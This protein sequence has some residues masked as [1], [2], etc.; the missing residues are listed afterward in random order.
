[1]DEL[2]QLD[3]RRRFV[4]K[5]T[6]LVK[7]ISDLILIDPNGQLIQLREQLVNSVVPLQ[8]PN[9]LLPI[10]SDHQPVRPL[11][12]VKVKIGVKR[13]LDDVL[14]LTDPMKI[15]DPL[16]TDNYWAIG[17]IIKQFR[18]N[19]QLPVLR[20]SAEELATNSPPSTPPQPQQ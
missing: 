7:H 1:M 13:Q 4:E 3:Q 8:Q 11:I 6:E 2:D 17:E 5:I 9:N 16:N 10:G 15:V 12:V 18:N 19:S 20:W 14:E